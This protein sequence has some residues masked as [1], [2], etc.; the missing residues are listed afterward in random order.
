MKNITAEEFLR[1][2]LESEIQVFGDGNTE[3]HTR[4]LA[5]LLKCLESKDRKI[6]EL[7]LQCAELTSK[8]NF[9]AE[10]KLKELLTDCMNKCN[11]SAEQRLGFIRME[12]LDDWNKIR[13][14]AKEE[15]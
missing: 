12:Y 10:A 4:D 9:N 11:W 2:K 15:V 5:H 1:E 7:E 8:I 14:G 3:F 6:E 13:E